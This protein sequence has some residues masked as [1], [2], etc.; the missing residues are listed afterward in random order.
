MTSKLSEKKNYRS[1]TDQHKEFRG[2]HSTNEKH[3][4]INYPQDLNENQESCML[5]FITE[6]QNIADILI[7]VLQKLIVAINDIISIKPIKK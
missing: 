7:R 5:L 2:K 3:G 4:F 6:H 1:F